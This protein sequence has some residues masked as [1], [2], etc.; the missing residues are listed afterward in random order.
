MTGGSV[1]SLPGR[2]AKMLPIL[3]TPIVQPASLDQRTNRSRACLS[4]SV[5]ASRFT[6]PFSVAAI[7]SNNIRLSHNRSLLMRMFVVTHF[8]QVEPQSHKG[9]EETPALNGELFHCHPRESGGPGQA[10]D[11]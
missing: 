5:S 2:R 1:S 6:P 3:S 8:S 9:H 10:T 11:L 4:R 7:L